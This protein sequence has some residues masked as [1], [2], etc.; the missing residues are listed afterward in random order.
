MKTSSGF[1]NA[2]QP[3]TNRISNTATYSDAWNSK[4]RYR[5]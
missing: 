5:K 3:T 1:L 2:V 4:R